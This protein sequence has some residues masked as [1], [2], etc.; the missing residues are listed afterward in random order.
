VY[1]STDTGASWTA[2]NT[3][4]PPYK[5]I[6]TLALDGAN[7]YA[8]TPGGIFVSTNSGTSWSTATGMT[9]RNVHSPN[10]DSHFDI[11]LLKYVFLFCRVNPCYI[12]FVV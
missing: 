3:G 4:L 12:V 5:Y 11:M 6:N 2:V 10:C 8:G 1:L 7:L 9:G